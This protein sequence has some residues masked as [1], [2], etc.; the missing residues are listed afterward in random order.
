MLKNRKGFVIESMLALGAFIAICGATVFF[1]GPKAGQT[2]H[3]FFS[4]NKN[5][6]KQVYK[7]EENRTPFYQD[8]NGKF[9]PA[10]KQDWRREYRENVLSTEPP[11][12][13]WQKYGGFVLL[14]IAF[15]IAFP[16]VAIGIFTKARNNLSQIIVGIEEAKKQLPKASQDILTANLS[17]KMD[18]SVKAKVKKIKGQLVAK[19]VIDTSATT[20]PATLPTSLSP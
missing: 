4:G 6:A 17:R 19:G 8:A 10:P 9:V 1:A 11:L 14:G 20:P 12:T 13:F 7:V 3:E 18:T 5:Q 2:I 15:L 16:T